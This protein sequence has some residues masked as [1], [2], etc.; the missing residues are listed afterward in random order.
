MCVHLEQ[1]IGRSQLMVSFF[2][3]SLTCSAVCLG[4]RCIAKHAEDGLWLDAVVRFAYS[5]PES[6]PV[7]VR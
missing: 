5:M 6:G 3:V 2:V 1:G 7:E 4:S